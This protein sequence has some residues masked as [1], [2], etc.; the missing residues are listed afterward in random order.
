VKIRRGGDFHQ[1]HFL[2]EH[3]L[4]ADGAGSCVHRIDRAHD[5]VEDAGHNFFCVKLRAVGN[6]VA[7]RP[8]L[9]AGLDLLQRAGLGILEFD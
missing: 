3:I 5:I 6:A 7:A 2:A 1:H 4:N 8:Q 9:V